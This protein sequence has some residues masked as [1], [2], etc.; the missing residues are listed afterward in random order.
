MTNSDDH[1]FDWKGGGS[2]ISYNNS[3]AWILRKQ[4]ASAEK[5]RETGEMVSSTSSRNDI[6]TCQLKKTLHFL[7]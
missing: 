7:W 3:D 6:L 5:D 2:W 1:L 4:L